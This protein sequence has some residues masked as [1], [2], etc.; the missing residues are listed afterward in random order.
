MSSPRHITITY[1]LTPPP[2]TPLPPSSPAHPIPTSNTLSFPIAPPSPLKIPY[3]SATTKY[4]TSTSASLLSAQAVLNEKLSYWKEAIG[5]GE[6]DKEA[7]EGKGYGRG[8]AM[9]M[10]A[11]VNGEM[12]S[13]GSGSEGD[14]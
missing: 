9:L 6:K 10:S 7:G 5:D 11:E 3:I 13:S 1:S 2:T 14:L 4:Y 8:K 12:E